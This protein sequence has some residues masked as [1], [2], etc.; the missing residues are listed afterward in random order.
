MSAR[1]QGVANEPDDGPN[2][3][4]EVVSKIVKHLVRLDGEMVREGFSTS[5]RQRNVAEILARVLEE[6]VR[7]GLMHIAVD[8]PSI[9]LDG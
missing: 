7:L 6:V 3:A 4:E 9:D 1:G 8:E 5:A 2:P